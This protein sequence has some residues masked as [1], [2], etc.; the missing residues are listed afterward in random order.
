VPRLKG[1][2]TQDARGMR[3]IMSRGY[4]RYGASN[5]P[6][7]GNLQN[8]QRAAK[9]RIKKLQGGNDLRRYR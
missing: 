6:R 7:P 1:Y 3:G 4:A 2:T 5:S 8:V 9:A